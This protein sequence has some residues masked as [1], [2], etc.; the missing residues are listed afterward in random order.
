MLDIAAIN[1]GAS[2]AGTGSGVYSQT[3]QS[4]GFGF[5]ARNLNASGT[6]IISTGQNA[7]GTY[8]V[9]GSGGSFNGVTT[10][11][12]ARNTSLGISEAIYSDNGGVVGRVNYWSGTTQFKI[13]GTGAVSTTA[14]NINGE[15]VTLYCPEAPEILFEDYG[16]GQLVN[17]SV[18]IE[19]D[20][21]I[22]KNIVVNEK[23]PLRVYIQL[24][25]DCNGVYVT[26]K[27]GSSFDVKELA[28]G[29]SN[30]KFQ[31]HIVG[32]R[33]DELLPNGRISKNA[34]MRFEPAPKNLETREV[35]PI[36][37]GKPATI[38]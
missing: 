32:N 37:I 36:D 4:A 2:G 21:T 9:A 22:A 8:L 13:I 14:E 12:H 23:H 15:R 5:D 20:P 29:Q 6:A 34:D 16:Q 1:F 17:G 25:D 18:H 30:A 35:T 7:G 38:K 19:I 28:S 24:E 3:T 33:A 10:G 11:L 31:Y 27:T 26:N